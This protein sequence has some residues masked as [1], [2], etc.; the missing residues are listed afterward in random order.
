MEIGFG[1]IGHANNQKE[2][3][4]EPHRSKPAGPL[5]SRSGDW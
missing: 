1:I 4:E 5:G 3:Q 2:A